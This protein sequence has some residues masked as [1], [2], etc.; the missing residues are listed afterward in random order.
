MRTKLIRSQSGE[1]VGWQL[2]LSAR[3]TDNWRYK[4]GAAWPCS[5]IGGHRIF[6]DVDSNGFCGMTIDG[7]QPHVETDIDGNEFDAIVAD[8]QPHEARHLWPKWR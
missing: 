7:K 5:V 4:P 6:V 8:H 3:D 1:V 2:W